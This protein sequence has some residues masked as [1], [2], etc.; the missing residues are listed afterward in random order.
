M[1]KEKIN[2]EQYFS[3]VYGERWAQLSTALKNPSKQVIRPNGFVSQPAKTTQKTTDF[4]FYTSEK[5][6][7]VQE[8]SDGLKK[9]YVMDLASIIC[10]QSLEVGPADFV[11][12]MCAAPG[13][14]SLILFEHLNQGQLWCNELSAARR[15]KLK[16]VI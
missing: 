9:Y 12:D 6:Q 4:P 1:K 13:G 10:A 2:F 3:E 14:K 11:L 16:N 15:Q 7:M 8:L 5:N